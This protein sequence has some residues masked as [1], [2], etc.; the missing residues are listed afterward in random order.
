MKKYYLLLA[1]LSI[2]LTGCI[3][4]QKELTKQQISSD[5]AQ[6]IRS[7]V[8][9]LDC[10]KQIAPNSRILVAVASDGALYNIVLL[11]SRTDVV[12]SL[13]QQCIVNIFPLKPFPEDMN[14]IDIFEVVIQIGD[15]GNQEN[16]NLT[17]EIKELEADFDKLVEERK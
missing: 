3:S 2:I 13:L 12:P 16:K 17:K 11:D 4:S 1:L 7:K 10:I 15:G 5:Y 14:N 9:T 6:S 8:Q